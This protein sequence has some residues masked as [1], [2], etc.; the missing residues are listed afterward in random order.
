MFDRTFRI[1]VL[2]AAAALLAA[3]DAGAASDSIGAL[4][5]TFRVRGTSKTVAV[6]HVP[7]PDPRNV[8][9][10]HDRTRLELSDDGT[11]AWTGLVRRGDVAAGTWQETSPGIVTG[12]LDPSVLADMDD[13]LTSGIRKHRGFHGA[14]VTC[15]IDLTP[16][17]F[18]KDGRKFTTDADVPCT[19]TGGLADIDIHLH[20]HY[21]GRRTTR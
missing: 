13:K 5:A 2:A 6:A 15:E 8:S 9:H 14:T 16:L 7:G 18:V 4:P 1:Y 20:A 12:T 19:V 11:F 10:G 21:R 17:V 3:T